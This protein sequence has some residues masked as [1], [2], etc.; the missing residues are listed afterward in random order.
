MILAAIV[1]AVIIL[2]A[3]MSR[4]GDVAVR[5]ARAE[6]QTITATVQTNGKIEPLSNFEA[7]APLA[8]T[9]KRVLVS[10]GEHVRAG[11]LLLELDDAGAEAQ[12]AKAQAQIR[13]AEADLSAVRS[14]GTRAEVLT[15]TSE[16]ASARAERDSAQRNLAA[17]RA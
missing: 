17:M 12:A 8:T 6:R 11:Q 5:A 7:H 2:G 3:F 14:G 15:T 16:L 13:A 9:V 1:V 4:R 10:Q